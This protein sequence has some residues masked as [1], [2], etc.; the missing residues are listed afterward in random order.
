LPTPRN[1]F[2]TTGDGGA[3]GDGSVF[4]IA[5]TAGGYASTSTTLV[6]FDAT[7]G[8]FPGSLI[9]D[10]NGDLFG[11]AL[12]GGA[13]GDGTVFEIVKTA[14]GYASAPT[15]VVSF[16]IADGVDPHAGLIADAKGDLFGTTALGGANGDGTV[17]EIPKTA[18]GYASTPTT[19]VSFNHANGAV[20]EAGLIADAKGDLLGTTE[21]GDA[22]GDGAVFEIAKTAGDYA[23]TPTTLRVL[24]GESIRPDPLAGQRNSA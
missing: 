21:G 12:E 4:E 17:F 6:S 24:R 3:N 23:S 2:G 14:G 18:G 5:K 20:P 7:N 11:A 19:L 16:N 10:S 13:N 9:V 15:T 8:E 22:N 1:L